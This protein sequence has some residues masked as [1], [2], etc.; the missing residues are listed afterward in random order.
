M[1]YLVLLPVLCS[2]AFAWIM[3]ARGIRKDAMA[4]EREKVEAENAARLRRENEVAQRPVTDS[5]LQ[6][7]LEDGSF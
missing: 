4:E 3:I 7:S 6:R 1:K 2:I 5:E